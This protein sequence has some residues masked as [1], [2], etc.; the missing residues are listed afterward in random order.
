MGYDKNLYN[1]AFDMDKIAGGDASAELSK[2]KEILNSTTNTHNFRFGFMKLPNCLASHLVPTG[3]TESSFK[4]YLHIPII[5]KQVSAPNMEIA[6]QEINIWNK[7]Y[8]YANIKNYGNCNVSFY[9]VNYIINNESWS[10]SRIMH[11]WMELTSDRSR[12]HYANDY[13]TR[14]FINKYPSRVHGKINKADYS[15]TFH[16]T[17]LQNAANE[18]NK[19]SIYHLSPKAMVGD[20]LVAD[21][22]PFSETFNDPNTDHDFWTNLVYSNAALADQV[23]TGIQLAFYS[24]VNVIK[25]VGGAVGDM[26]NTP[27]TWSHEVENQQEYKDMVASLKYWLTAIP[28]SSVTDHKNFSKFVNDPNTTSMIANFLKI[29]NKDP[30]LSKAFA[31][32]MAELMDVADGVLSGKVAFKPDSGYELGTGLIKPGRSDY[33]VDAMRMY[34]KIIARLP[35]IRNSMQMGTGEG[36]DMSASGLKKPPYDTQTYMNWMFN[37]T[38]MEAFKALFW[39]QTFP[40]MLQSTIDIWKRTLFYNTMGVLYYIKD[41]GPISGSDALVYSGPSSPLADLV[42][43]NYARTANWL[44]KIHPPH[45]VINEYLRNKRKPNYHRQATDDMMTDINNILS[46]N[47]SIKNFNIPKGLMSETELYPVQQIIIKGAFPTN[48]SLDEMD[49]DAEQKMSMC[50]VKFS[51]VDFDMFGFKEGE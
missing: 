19:G 26:V 2:F 39:V 23:L 48:L 1:V 21:V 30:E 10:F 47:M 44:C 15:K 3:I 49:F 11:K 38:V 40:S 24:L 18:K 14:L 34:E 37:P 45:L 27:L 32:N 29:I 22:V 7:K 20:N 33:E 46:L 25:N 36:H 17:L 13:T 50:K 28:N 5:A 42:G 4:G 43:T 35:E 12:M 9:D 6:E 8:V 31:D 41:C 51:M 16:L